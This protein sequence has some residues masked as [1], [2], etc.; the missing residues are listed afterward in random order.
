MAFDFST[1]VFSNILLA[2]L[3][4]V[5]VLGCSDS[6]SK[7]PPPTAENYRIQDLENEW[8]NK[9]AESYQHYEKFASEI[10]QCQEV[11]LFE[12][13]PNY[14]WEEELL[15][16]ERKAHNPISFNFY[17]FETEFYP[18]PI[19]LSDIDSSRLK[20]LYCQKESFVPFRGFKPCGGF[21]ADWGIR[22]R[23]GEQDYQV[24]ICFGC[25][26]M[27]TSDGNVELTCDIWDSKIFEDL[28]NPYHKLR[29]EVE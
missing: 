27:M 25:G 18:T 22:W 20:E 29:P 7:R 1:S 17:S 13:L 11:Q 5:F 19:R 23:N 12:G 16:R 4:S 26:E 24:L 21:H 28:L 15:E 2:S 8:A 3:A 6:P 9:Y 10:K 14:T